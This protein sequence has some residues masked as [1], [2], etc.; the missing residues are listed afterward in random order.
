VTGAWPRRLTAVLLL[1]CATNG[2]SAGSHELGGAV[3]QAG[4]VGKRF[5]SVRELK[6]ANVVQQQTDYS[7]G[8]AALAT[9]LK[10]AYGRQVDEP[11]VISGLMAV[12][13]AELVRQQGFSMLDMKRYV[14]SIGLR[15]RGYNVQPE[16]LER[17]QVPTIALIDVRGYRHF[18]VLKRTS[19][20]R[21]YL[22]DPALGN[23]V[24]DKRDFLAAWN[25]VVFAVIG[26]GFDR[27]TALL[28]PSEP[29]AV[30]YRAGLHQPVSSAALLELGFTHAE[31]F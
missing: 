4:L 3:P 24:M 13:D 11:Q 8:A 18:V 12:A 22:A 9:I 29:L 25:G 26:K 31:L 10:Y 6:Y 7:C 2:A 23:R 14:E 28:R 27:Q 15:G 1:A 5:L 19:R 20:S 30:R 17:I 16:A 21:V